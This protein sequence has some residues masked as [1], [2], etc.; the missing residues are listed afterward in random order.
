MLGSHTGA[1]KVKAQ[2][3][4]ERQI[5]LAAQHLLETRYRNMEESHAQETQAIRQ[6]MQVQRQHHENTLAALARQHD[7]RMRQ[8]QQRIARYAEAAAGGEARCQQL[9]AYAAQLDRHLEQ[10]IAL[11]GEFAQTLGYRDNTIRL[12]IEQL[13]ADRKLLRGM[14]EE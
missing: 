3:Q 7:E 12:I 11:V 5:L 14:G 1:G 13:L 10:G 6:Q 9:A 4:Q 8:Q 2:W